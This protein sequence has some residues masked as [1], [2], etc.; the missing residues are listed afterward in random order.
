MSFLST[1]WTDIEKVLG[2]AQAIAPVVAVVDPNAAG[3]IAVAEK[4]ISALQPTIATVAQAAT[5]AL[6]HEQ[7]VDQVTNVVAT[8]AKILAD[9]GKIV[10]SANDA[11]QALAPVIHAA[12]AASGLASTAPA[13]P[14]APAAP[15]A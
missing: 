8:G 5:G 3:G 2:V 14:A 11:I 1:L 13:A 15:G 7:L 10:A 12:V 9:N 4:A 6:T